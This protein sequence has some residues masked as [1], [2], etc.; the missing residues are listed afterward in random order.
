VVGKSSW[1]VVV[2]EYRV[3]AQ[4]YV[5]AQ[6]R[7]Y[8][9]SA[10]VKHKHRC[11]YHALVSSMLKKKA[12]VLHESDSLN[13]TSS[14]PL[15]P[16]SSHPA[17][18]FSLSIYSNSASVATKHAATAVLPAIELN[19]DVAAPGVEPAPLSVPLVELAGA[20]LAASSL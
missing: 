10:L 20:A 9:I 3:K 11:E 17:H 8:Q 7:K 19:T 1:Y 14:H 4:V 16:L 18:Y 5:S 13:L 12:L 2:T 6:P 15:S